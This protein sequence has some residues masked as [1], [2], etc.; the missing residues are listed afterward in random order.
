MRQQAILFFSGFLLSASLFAQDD[1]PR[2]NSGELIQ[3][4]IQLHDEG[5]YKESID[6]YKKIPR[7]DTNYQR[8]LYEMSLSYSADSNYIEAVRACETGLKLPEK[9]YELDLYN[10]YGSI[11]DDMGDSVRALRIYDSALLKYPHAQGLLLNKATTLLRMNK[12][13]EAT[14]ICQYLVLRNPFYASAHFRLAVCALKES[15]LVPAL[16]SFFTYL[17]ISPDGRYQGSAIFQLSN[18]IKGTD[19]V[20]KLVEDRKIEEPE[21]YS[22]I[23]QIILSKAALDKKY[24]L[25]GSLD[26]P[27]V[28]QIQVLMEKLEYRPDENDFWMQVYVPL[29]KSIFTDKQFENAVYFAFSGLDIESIKK[30]IKNNKKDLKEFAETISTYLTKIKTTRT[31]NY[32]QRLTS[33]DIYQMDEEGIVSAKGK[34]NGTNPSGQWEYYFNNGNIKAIGNYTAEGKKDGEWKYYYSSGIES[35][36]EVWKNGV[37][38]GLDINRNSFGVISSKSNYKNGELDGESINY[39]AIGHPYIITHYVNGKRQGTYIRYS[40]SGRKK[41][42]CNYSDDKLDGPYKSFYENGQADVITTYSKGEVNG[43]YKEYYDNG[44]LSFEGNYTDGKATGELKNYHTNG[45][46]QRK[47]TYENDLQTGEEIEYNDEGVVVAKILYEKGKANGLA[48]YYDDDSK[49]YSSILFKNESPSVTKYFDKTGKEISS[50]QIKNK[51]VLLDVYSPEGIKISSNTYNDKGVLINGNTFFYS[52]GKIKETNSYKD[53]DLDGV[54][55][56]YHPN[57]VKSAE[58]NYTAGE[59]NGAYKLFYPNGKLET[60]GWYSD[61]S[62]TDAWLNYN[63]KG[64]LTERSYYVNGD[65]YGYKEMYFANGKIDD[66]EIYRNGWLIGLNQYDTSGKLLYTTTFT[67]GNGKYKEIFPDGKTKSEGDYVQGEWHGTFKNYY[68]DGSLLSVKYFNHGQADSIYREYYGAGKISLEGMY[69]MGKRTGTWKYYSMDG[70]LSQEETYVD[71]DQNGKYYSYYSNGKVEK[72]IDFKNDERNG[73]YKKY[74]EDG[75][76]CSVIYYKDGIPV[77]YS[78]PDKNGQL[79]TPIKLIGGN[80]KVVTYYANGTKSSEFEFAEGKTHGAYKSYHPNGKL[81][82]EATDEYGITNDKVRQYYPD[83]SLAYE[84][85]YYWDNLDG[86]YKEYYANGK[87][88]EEGEYFNGYLNGNRKFYD[89]TGKLIETD[90]YYYGVKLSIKK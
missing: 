8:T 40:S 29:F 11:V 84:Y 23:E 80:G 65:M 74:A 58:I 36:L 77:S 27:I 67:N 68:C 79:V 69:K 47:R 22:T 62:E 6:I 51:T 37:K 35:G 24:K 20:I 34:M 7:N 4:A 52:N 82:Y 90:F 48:E 61:G 76:L 75:S 10:S 85:N 25:I 87:I 72:E 42:E 16:M 71:G 78:Y 9:D 45:K 86:P 70:K 12:V 73:A 66:E 53:G 57:A 13:K 63:E 56:G 59:K 46:L 64:I 33:E 54:S 3:K 60:T 41:T 83:G 55:I 39:F 28:R 31:A 32:K 2:I 81:Y 15:R 5:K 88:K 26:D 49:L 44:K 50:S 14:D 17:M 43:S 19:D 38:E 1:N 89:N 21:Y 30:Y 18:I